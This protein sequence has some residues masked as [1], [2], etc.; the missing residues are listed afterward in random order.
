MRTW[1]LGSDSD[2]LVRAIV[3]SQDIRTSTIAILR[4]GFSVGLFQL[5]FAI[6]YSK[7]LGLD[8]SGT[9]NGVDN[10]EIYGEICGRGF[11][12]GSMFGIFVAI[13]TSL[14]RSC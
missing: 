13:V 10:S 8:D 4:L 12:L 7:R 9:T 14:V 5:I 2:V 3:S 1:H 6:I 11:F